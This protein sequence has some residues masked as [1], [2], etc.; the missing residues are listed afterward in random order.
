MNL[1]QLLWLKAAGGSEPRERVAVGNP[2]VFRVNTAQALGIEIPIAAT[3]AGSGEP[4]PDNV[5]PISGAASVQIG[6]NGKNFCPLPQEETKNGVTLTRNADGSCTITGTNGSGALYFDCIS[7]FDST[8]FAGYLLGSGYAGTNATARMRFTTDDYTNILNISDEERPI[9][10]NGKNTKIAIRVA[11]GYQI[12]D[13]GITFR[14]L[15]RPPDSASGFEPY[16]GSIT[17]ASFQ[18]AVYGGKL[19]VNADGT[20]TLTV[21][22]GLV[23]L[24]D[25]SQLKNYTTNASAGSYAVIGQDSV[26][27]GC[28]MASKCKVVP[29]DDRTATANDNRVYTNASGNIYIRASVAAAVTSAAELFAIFGG[30]QFVYELATPQTVSLSPGQVAAVIGTNHV[31]TD[32]AGE[33]TVTYVR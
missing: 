3:Q 27:D 20:G 17:G 14:P 29:F 12:P 23:N 6:V 18:D 2:A 21:T 15:L 32:T 5:R 11:G 25:A 28:T 1:R 16:T 24:T 19:T 26:L 8:L 10:D 13:G 4:S 30:G 7:S 22:H 31:W 33:N 9:T